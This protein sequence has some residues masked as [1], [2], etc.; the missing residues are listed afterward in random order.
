MRKRDARIHTRMIRDCGSWAELYRRLKE[1]VGTD[2]KAAGDAFE[3]FVQ[4]Y[5]RTHPTYQAQLTD[6]WLLHQVPADVRAQLGLGS[7]EGVDL[8]ARTGR[9]DFWAIQAKFVG[10]PDEPLTRAKVNSF[11]SFVFHARRGKF[12]DGFIA[13]ISTKPIRKR[14]LLPSIHELGLDRWLRLDDDGGAGWR[15]VVAFLKRGEAPRPKPHEPWPHVTDAIDAAVAHFATASRGR[16]KMACGTGKS[17]VALWT[18][19]AMGAK[20]ILV[21]VPSLQLVQRAVE[22]WSRE[23]L[24]NGERPAWMC[25]CSDDTVVDDVDDFVTDTYELGLQTETDPRVIAEWLRDNGGTKIVFATYQSSEAWHI[26]CACGN[27]IA[28]LADPPAD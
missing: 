27:L 17:M 9:G 23:Y 1:T 2:R 24:A 3:V 22:D 20:T 4:A 16:L 11:V 28:P 19:R 25:V 7:D 10:D 8:V 18:A 13:H 15:D 12:T 21:V 26:M 5:L 14:R 6:V